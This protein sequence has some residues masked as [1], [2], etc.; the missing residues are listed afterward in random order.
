MF[1]PQVLQPGVGS[2][3]SALGQRDPPHLVAECILGVALER[4]AAGDQSLILVNFSAQ[5]MHF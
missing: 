2:R 5:R 4:D 1:W 3:G